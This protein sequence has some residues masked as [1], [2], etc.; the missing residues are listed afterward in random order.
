M[1][2]TPLPG[3]DGRCRPRRRRPG[4]SA[5]RR[6]PP[7]P[8]AR[9]R[10]RRARR[11]GAA[12][13]ASTRTVGTWPPARPA[14]ASS[15]TTTCW[16]RMPQ[17][18]RSAGWHSP[19]PAEDAA[20]GRGDRRPSRVE[21][22]AV[23]RRLIRHGREPERLRERLD[24]ALRV[25]EVVGPRRAGPSGP[26]RRPRSARRRVATTRGGRPAGGRSPCRSRRSRCRGGPG[27][28][29]RRRRRGGSRRAAGGGPSD[30]PTT[31]SSR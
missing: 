20:A 15:A 13:C 2:A 30:R 10:Q 6:R 17:A 4:S 21:R 25:V 5:P 18:A 11:R 3:R 1:P 23:R 9:P 14:T 28:G 31:G 19:T 12:G 8:R 22:E 27:G 29:S 24:E 26:V 16:A 7:A